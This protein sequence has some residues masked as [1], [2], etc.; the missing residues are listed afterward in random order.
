MFV[1]LALAAFLPLSGIHLVA[2]TAFATMTALEPTFLRS[3]CC[4]LKMMALKV[5]TSPDDVIA[6]PNKP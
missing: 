4:L 1:N 6:D 2:K 5:M 3:P